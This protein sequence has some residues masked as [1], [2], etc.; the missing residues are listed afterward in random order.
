MAVHNVRGAV[1]I[2]TDEAIEFL[3]LAR[4]IVEKVRALR[5]G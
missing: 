3:A 5:R 1:P 4:G 2:T